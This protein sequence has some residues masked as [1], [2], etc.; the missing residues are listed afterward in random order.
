MRHYYWQGMVVIS[1]SLFSGADT[2]FYF[3]SQDIIL[4][5]ISKKTIPPVIGTLNCWKVFDGFNPA[6][7]YLYLTCDPGPIFQRGPSPLSSFF[8]ARTVPIVVLTDFLYIFCKDS[9]LTTP[10][11]ETAS[12]LNSKGT[13]KDV[14]QQF[15]IKW[16]I[17]YYWLISC[18][19]RGGLIFRQAS[20]PTRG[21]PTRGDGSS[22]LT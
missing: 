12:I 8:S 5:A 1:S 9:Y 15:T 14:C 6:G 11:R 13:V 22:G 17:A 10:F 3:A 4:Y 21:G 20:G 2:I 18:V 7:D 19:C 16:I